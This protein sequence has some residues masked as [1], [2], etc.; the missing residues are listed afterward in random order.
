MLTA[1]ERHEMIAKIRNLPAALE[2]A[3]K[4]LGD[5][6]LETPYREGGWTV[7]QVVHHLADAH[8]NSFVRMKLMLTEK[9][10]TLKPYDQNE[11]ARTLDA[12][13][14]SIQS[15]LAILKGLHE[16]WSVLLESLPESNW[17]RSAVHP[18]IG[19]VTL[20]EMLLRW[21]SHAENHVGQITRLRVAKGW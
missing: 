3:V 6:Q 9:R 10:P 20:D 2:A 12:T 5:K 14:T 16:R 8:L 13:D 11:W 18:E 15:S 4:D 17:R 19:E 21:A 1:V 7:R